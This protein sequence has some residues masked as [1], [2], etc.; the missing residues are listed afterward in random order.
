MDQHWSEVM[1]LAEQY[2]FIVQTYGGTAILATHKN[3]LD[4]YGE[5]KY[6]SIQ[7]MN[8][9]CLKELGYPECETGCQR[10]YLNKQRG[11]QN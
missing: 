2:G 6:K 11:C 8:G 10:C 4:H 3:Q 1:K 9:K 7:K 5:E